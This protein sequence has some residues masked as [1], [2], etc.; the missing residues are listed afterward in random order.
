M[1]KP[2]ETEYNGYRFRSRLEARWAVFFDILGIPYEYEKEGYDLNGK[3]YLPDFWVPAWDAFVE[4]KGEAPTQ[5]E[6]IKCAKLAK[7]SGKNTLLIH[8]TP[9]PSGHKI[10]YFYSSG[11]CTDTLGEFRQC[12]R[13]PEIFIVWKDDNDNAYG[14]MS[15][16]HPKVEEYMK[17]D[18]RHECLD[19]WPLVHAEIEQAFNAARSARFEYGRRR[20]STVYKIKRYKIRSRV[21]SF[22]KHKVYS[23]PQPNNH[24]RS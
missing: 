9:I 24:V 10:A 23:V 3:W 13:C 6:K 21:L 16:G 11:E 20:P 18:P 12:R 4:I 15:I 1:I 8:G 22:A 7:A 17:K 14:A 2:I 5:E 19:R